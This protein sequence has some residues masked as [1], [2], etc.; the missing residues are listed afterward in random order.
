[1]YFC[2]LW[3]DRNSIIFTHIEKCFDQISGA[4]KAQKLVE[5]HN[6]QT[7]YVAY[8]SSLIALLF[9]LSYFLFNFYLS[10][11]ICSLPPTFF[12]SFFLSFFSLSL[13]FG[14]PFIWLLAYLLNLT[15][16]YFFLS[17]TF[18]FTRFVLC[19]F[20]SLAILL[21]FCNFI[22]LEIFMDRV[23]KNNVQ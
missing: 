22:K 14:H 16:V 17:F 1:M 23:G 13:S 2:L 10:L 8:I 7:M 19:S 5:I 20:F 9:Y 4:R 12:L 6:K 11:F 3:E 18:Y 15:Y 21:P